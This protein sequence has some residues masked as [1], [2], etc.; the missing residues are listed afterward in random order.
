V[1]EDLDP[2]ATADALAALRRL[3][4]RE[5]G[6]GERITQPNVEGEG[7]AFTSPDLP[8]PVNVVQRDDKLVI[9]YG[10]EATEEAFAPSGTLGE[11]D[12]F[13]TAA[14]AL[15]DYGVSLFVDGGPALDLAESSGATAD[16]GYAQAQPYL[17]H[18]AYLI[19][20]ASLDEDRSRVRA[21]LGLTE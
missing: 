6:P 9:A 20:G 3:A 11:S 16:P 17:Q 19:T 14:D 4:E 15:G 13:T 12:T 18:L 2:A 5:T 7:Y 1:I 10:D 8:Q 21:V